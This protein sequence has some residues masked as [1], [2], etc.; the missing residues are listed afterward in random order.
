MNILLNDFVAKQGHD[1]E[2]KNTTGM[3]EEHI[4]EKNITGFDSIAEDKA[5][6]TSI[7]KVI[8][9]KSRGDVSLIGQ[10]AFENVS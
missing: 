8:I 4:D 1:L 2:K 9:E 5:I 6:E 10:D 7:I 3:I